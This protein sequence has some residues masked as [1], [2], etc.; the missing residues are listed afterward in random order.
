MDAS[1]VVAAAIAAAV[2]ARCAAAAADRAARSASLYW[3]NATLK[4]DIPCED[5]SDADMIEVCAQC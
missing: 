4:S 5:M 2:S 3:I 1:T